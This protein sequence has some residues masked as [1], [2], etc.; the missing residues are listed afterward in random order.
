MK[1]K[2]SALAFTL[3]LGAALALFSPRVLAAPTKVLSAHAQ[4]LAQ[5]KSRYAHISRNLPR[6]RVVKRELYES[7]EGGELFAY[8]DG[9]N[10]R[11]IIATYYGETGNARYEYSFQSGTLFFARRTEERYIEPL[12]YDQPTVKPG[13]VR[14]RTDERFYFSGGKL[15]RRAVEV[16]EAKKP[17]RSF[18]SKGETPKDKSEAARVLGQAREA[19]QKAKNPEK[20]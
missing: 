16:H 12:F 15:F 6:Y 8:F 20:G 10:L 7:T 3:C 14:R 9:K 13:T 5:A 18:V 1:T 4:L 2:T 19:V 17:L 11:R